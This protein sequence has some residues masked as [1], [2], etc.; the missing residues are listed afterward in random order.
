MW[1]NNATTYLG[2]VKNAAHEKL[3]IDN[4][5]TFALKL[6][7][8]PDIRY[9]DAK[10]ATEIKDAFS[11]LVNADS[12]PDNRGDEVQGDDDMVKSPAASDVD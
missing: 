1:C 11:R 12:I 5:D 3:N 7:G 2:L 6:L 4:L 10:N 9:Y 8:T